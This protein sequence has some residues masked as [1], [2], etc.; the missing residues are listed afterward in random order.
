MSLIIQKFGGSSVRDRTC[1]L[2]A[3]GIVKEAWERGD[4]TVV[5]LSAQG[6]TTDKLLACAHE[7]AAAPSAR[8]L[9][10]LLATGETASTAL[11]AIALHSLGVP[12]VSLSGWQLPV[13]TDAVHG[14]AEITEIETVRLERELA[15]HR[16]VLV[17]GF[18]GVD[19]TDDMTTLGRG[20]SDTSAV[21]L[22]AY[23]GAEKCIIYTDVDGVYTTDPRICPTA[24]RLTAISRSHMLR[25]A[26]HGAQVLH[27][28]SVVLADR[29]DVTLE[30]RSCE[31]ESIGTLVLPH[32]ENGEVTGITRR[33]A[34]GISHVTAIGRGLPSLAALHAAVMAVEGANIAVLAVA[35]GEERI[36]LSVANEDA[37]AALCAVH[38]ALIQ[39]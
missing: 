27:D 1:L 36:T 11:G 13:R 37:D 39:N 20:G 9:D 3:M 34:G 32:A 2:H 28:R 30:V 35:E 23:L 4:D 21:A 31:R 17:A 22:A 33:K 12:A 7:I 38:D 18:Q 14:E 26:A 10:A 15:M 29:H 19:E 24:R 5:V 6:G 8:E 25:L 16:V